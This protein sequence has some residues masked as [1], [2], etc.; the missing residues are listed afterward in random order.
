MRQEF[1]V[2]R[3]V[4]NLHIVPAE[5]LQT[6]MEDSNLARMNK[7]ELLAIIR[8]RSD[9]QKSWQSTLGKVLRK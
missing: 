6:L 5:N 7:A 4:A 8:Q 9:Q 3:D 1:E 2:L